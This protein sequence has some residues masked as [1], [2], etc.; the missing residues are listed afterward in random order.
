MVKK[1]TK[2]LTLDAVAFGLAASAALAQEGGTVS[3]VSRAV[4]P[5]TDLGLLIRNILSIIFFIAGLLAF[6]YLL[7]GGLQWITSGGDKAAATA[8][9]DRITA[10]LVGLIIIVAAFAVTLVLER[11]FG[12]RILSGVSFPTAQN[13]AGTGG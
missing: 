9:R 5:F 6:I 4:T 3:S 12:I 8:A 1:I 10:A 2:I 13:T 7:I 11:V